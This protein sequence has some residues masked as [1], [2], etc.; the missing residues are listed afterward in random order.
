MKRE[1]IRDACRQEEFI[2]VLQQE[3]LKDEIKKSP[4]EIKDTEQ[5]IPYIPRPIIP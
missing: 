2:Q 5:N 4:N 1:I 3:Q